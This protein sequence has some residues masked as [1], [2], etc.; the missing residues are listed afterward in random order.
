MKK[1][2][3]SLAALA[4][5]TSKADVVP[6]TLTLSGGTYEFSAGVTFGQR[7]LTSDY[8]EIFDLETLLSVGTIPAGWTSFVELTSPQPVGVSVLDDP[9]ID[10]VRFVWTGGTVFGPTILGTFDLNVDP[11]AVLAPATQ[12]WVGSAHDIVVLGGL[13]SANI[14]NIPRPEAVPES[15]SSAVALLAGFGI[16]ALLRKGH[17]KEN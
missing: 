15:S 12:D 3:L 5:L 8:F 6:L 10:N 7:L 1:T 16:M 17:V 4:A 11:A 13:P 2:L 9:L 14:S